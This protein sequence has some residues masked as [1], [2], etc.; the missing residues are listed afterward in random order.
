MFPI[1]SR[2]LSVTVIVNQETPD[3]S[4]GGGSE[5]HMNAGMV[6]TGVEVVCASGGLTFG[7]MIP[8]VQSQ[9]MM[10]PGAVDV[11]PLNVQFRVAPPFESEQV[12]EVSGP[13]TPKF[14]AA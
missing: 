9:A 2:T 14:A 7:A 6:S 5:L 12:S 4:G 13:V 10:L 1:S 3:G 11:L 8:Y